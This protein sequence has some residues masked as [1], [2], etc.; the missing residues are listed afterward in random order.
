[1]NNQPFIFFFNA[2][3]TRKT[4][5]KKTKQKK[6]FK[7]LIRKKKKIFGKNTILSIKN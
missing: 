1:L 3:A 4:N 2:T 7:N 6:D 5:K